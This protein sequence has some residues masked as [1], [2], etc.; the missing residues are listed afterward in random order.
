MQILQEVD[1]NMPDDH[2]AASWT[3]KIRIETAGDY[4][5]ST[6]SDDGSYLWIGGELVV[7]AAS[8]PLLTDPGG[9]LASLGT[10]SS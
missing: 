7:D 4:M 3:G 8:M 1:D 10:S 2:F 5:F 6:A 9:G